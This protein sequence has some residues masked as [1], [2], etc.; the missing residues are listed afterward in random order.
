MFTVAT[1]VSTVPSS[2]N[3]DD[4]VSVAVISGA[5]VGTLLL[6]IIIIILVVII[7][8]S[9]RRKKSRRAYNIDD[10]AKLSSH[11]SNNP[12]QHNHNTSGQSHDHTGSDTLTKVARLETVNALY[13]PTKVK[14]LDSLL[15]QHDTSRTGVIGCDVIITPNPSYAV[16]PNSLETGKECEYQY[17]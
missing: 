11:I 3:D 2:D 9:R 14:S 5:V 16:G 17:E 1:D 10:K 15:R 6:I 13:L 7:L 12:Q 8:C 4:S